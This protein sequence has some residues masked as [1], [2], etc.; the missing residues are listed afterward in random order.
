M[1][2]RGRVSAVLMLMPQLHSRAKDLREKLREG[3]DKVDLPKTWMLKLPL[4][5]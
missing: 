5:G 1:P 2:S 3:E 4:V